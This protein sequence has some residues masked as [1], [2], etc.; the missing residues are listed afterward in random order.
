MDEVD[1]DARPIGGYLKIAR[2][3]E[4]FASIYPTILAFSGG[5]ER[6]RSARRVRRLQRRAGQRWHTERRFRASWAVP[7]E[8]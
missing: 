6:E 7:F 4:H 2:N 5:R 8:R 3:G 1:V